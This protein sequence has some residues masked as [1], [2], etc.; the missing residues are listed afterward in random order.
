[1]KSILPLLV[2][3]TPP[4]TDRDDTTETAAQTFGAMLAGMMAVKAVK[5]VKTGETDETGGAGDVGA[6]CGRP[7]EPPSHRAAEPVTP[8]KAGASQRAAESPSLALAAALTLM[9][10]TIA[11]IVTGQES[12]PADSDAGTTAP[13]PRD[14]TAPPA[15]APVTATVPVASAKPAVPM[16]PVI[17]AG[18]PTQE[19][20]PGDAKITMPDAA[21]LGE[22]VVVEKLDVMQDAERGTRNAR[23]AVTDPRATATPPG[24]DVRVDRS[25]GTPGSG[26]LTRPPASQHARVESASSP[27]TAPARADV[28]PPAQVSGKAQAQSQT[29][30]QN[31]S[32]DHKDH[33]DK[34]T[35]AAEPVTS[36][37]AGASQ[38]ARHPRESG[39]EPPGL[40]LSAFSPQLPTPAVQPSSRP[41]AESP[42]S[43]PADFMPDLTPATGTD[44]VSLRLGDD[45]TRL[46]VTVRGDTVH[47]RIVAPDAAVAQAL[48]GDVQEMQRALGD[49]GFGDAKIVVNQNSVGSL[50]GSAG[51]R[52][53]PD[54]PDSGDA[55][56]RNGH[57]ADRSQ[58]QQ[59]RSAH[60]HRSRRERERRD[61]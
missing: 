37:K 6:A 11:K 54:N 47:A 26:S 13:Q 7:I 31:G 40:Q 52:F 24:A 61:G 41:A 50:D 14:G 33:Q 49:K 19:V 32:M 39:G 4:S 22:N 10:P 57:Q 16:T 38:R 23:L 17:P 2:P 5:A 27:P 60:Q 9:P 55:D 21:E 56:R 29:Q 1:M 3:T 18:L 48:T 43:R 36:A 25:T 58:D 34:P 35:A 44:R 20:V 42:S 15:A 8:A 46:Q 59:H 45:G 12:K 28:L 53:T 30:S 51:R